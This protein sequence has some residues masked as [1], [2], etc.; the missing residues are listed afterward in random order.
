MADTK[1]ATKALIAEYRADADKMNAHELPQPTTQYLRIMLDRLDAAHRRER[2]KR[3]AECDAASSPLT[4]DEAIAH[5]DEVAGDCGTACKREHRQLADWLRELRSRRSA[6]RGDCAKLREALEA[7]IS[8]YKN[9]DLCDMNYGERCHDPANV[10]VNVPLC[11]A[12]HE[13]RAALAAPQL[14]KGGEK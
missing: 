14:Q 9:A 7:I 1:E 13:A 2:G 12:I 3:D 6:E 10:C 5:A 8:G 11:K 4:L